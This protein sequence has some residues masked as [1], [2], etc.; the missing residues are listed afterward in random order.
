MV[1]VLAGLFMG[2]PTLLSPSIC[3]VNAFDKIFE[4]R[5]L[6]KTE[7]NRDANSLGK[8]KL[9]PLRFDVEPQTDFSE[10]PVR[11]LNSLRGQ[12]VV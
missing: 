12:V 6:S 4:H 9:Q 8:N 7:L 5:N 11:N 3:Y 2:C 1:V 10:K